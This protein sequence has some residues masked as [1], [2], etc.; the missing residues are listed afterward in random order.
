MEVPITR[1]QFIDLQSK[2]MDWFLYNRDIRHK[3]V[4]ESNDKRMNAILENGR[5]HKNSK[6]GL[7]NCLNLPSHNSTTIILQTLLMYK[8]GNTIM[9][10]PKGCSTYRISKIF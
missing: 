8:F 4:Y 2:S 3:I 1:N 7:M 10:L 9:G 6:N 5:D